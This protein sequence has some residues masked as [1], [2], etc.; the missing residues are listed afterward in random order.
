MSDWKLRNRGKM[1]CGCKS[2][3]LV[4][5]I[6]ARGVASYDINVLNELDYA[7]FGGSGPRSI[8]SKSKL[9]S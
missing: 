5:S 9:R 8:M 2:K 6:V 4:V 7:T 1:Y 3:G